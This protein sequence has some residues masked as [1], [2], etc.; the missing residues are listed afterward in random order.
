M[1][2]S[3]LTLSGVLVVLLVIWMFVDSARDVTV[4]PEA[5]F[6]VDT[7]AIDG[8]IIQN[9]TSTIELKR[10]G[11]AW[12]L[13]QPIDYPA[14]SR[15][16][17]DLLKKMD[18]MTIEHLVTH[19]ADKDTTY[20]F[21]TSAVQVTVLS[22][23]EAVADFMVGKTA[24]NNRHTYCRMVEDDAIYRVKGAFSSQ[25][26]R[27]QK[28]WRDKIILEIDREAIVRLDYVYPEESFS[29]VK[30]DTAWFMERGRTSE[31]TNERNVNQAGSL[32]SKF[33]SFDFL[34]GD[35]A[36]AVNFS[37]PEL[38]ITI[39]TNTEDTYKMTLVPQDEEGNR[40]LVKKDGIENTVFVIYK[41]T[42]N[43]MMKKSVDFKA[44]ETE[45]S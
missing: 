42:A 31:P 41:G 35:S 45:E 2:K 32:L 33:R 39:T 25:L 1:N 14:E 40:Y 16:V 37:D 12:R 20:G 21:D 10:S 4:K 9:N 11:S 17:T 34:D 44:V 13:A 19:A 29:L 30:A 28:D 26:R 7:S 18:E 22:G 38:V 3:F 15:F 36:R 43:S 8:L 5:F 27:S 23:S 24:N 6:D